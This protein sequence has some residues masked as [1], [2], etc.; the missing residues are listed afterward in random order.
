M[1]CFEDGCLSLVEGDFEV[2]ETASMMLRRTGETQ[3]NRPSGS[4]RGE[5]KAFPTILIRGHFDLIHTA[6]LLVLLPEFAVVLA[7]EQLGRKQ[8]RPIVRMERLEL[9]RSVEDRPG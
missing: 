7:V 9:A 8:E 4:E 5:A 2:L 3:E 1:Q 6:S